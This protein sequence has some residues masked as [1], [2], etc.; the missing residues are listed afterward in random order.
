MFARGEMTWLF[1]DVAGPP[2]F[3]FSVD[4]LSGGG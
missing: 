1:L 2:H 3:A 4:A